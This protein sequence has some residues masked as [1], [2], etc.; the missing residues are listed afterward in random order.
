MMKTDFSAL[1]RWYY[2]QGFNIIPVHFK[3]KKPL[4]SWKEWQEKNI[5]KEIY[6]VFKKKEFVGNNCALITGKIY[7][8]PNI[9]K[10]L[11][12]IDIDNKL[13]IDIFLSYFGEK[14][15]EG[16][17]QKTIVVQ[18]EDSKEE[19]AHIYFISEK[20]ITKRGRISG[21]NKDDKMIPLIEVKS[22][23]STYVVCPPSIYKTGYQYQIIG[24]NQIQVLNEENCKMLEDVLDRIYQK[25]S[26][27]YNPSTSSFSFLT[28]ELKNMAKTLNIDSVKDKIP[29]GARNNTL[30]AVGD[31]LL[32]NHYNS[33]D[34]ELLKDFF[35]KINEKLCEK[36][37]ERKELE[38]IW[39]QAV[40]YIK[41]SFDEKPFTKNY[42]TRQINNSQTKEDSNKK[43]YTVFKFTSN[44]HIYEAVI[45][46]GK[47]FFITFDNGY[48]KIVEEIDD[49]TRAIKP[50]PLEEYASEPY[51]FENKEE[52]VKLVKMIKVKGVSIDSLFF[53][54]NEFV[55]KFIVHH[56]H[57]LD[58]ISVLILFSYFQ[59]RFP[60]VPYTMFVSDNSSGKSSIGNVF[61]TLGYRTINMTDPTTANVFRIFGTVE[62]GQ[63]TLVL[64][65]AEKIDQ[66]KDMMSILKTG[67]EN[68]KKV[69]RINPFTNKPDHY[70]TFGLKMMLAERS[71]NPSNSRGILDRTFVI[72]N[73]KGRPQLNIKEVKNPLKNSNNEK[74][75]KDLLFIKKTLLIFRL[76]HLHKIQDIET[77]LEDRDKEL[78]K[79]ILQLF[80]GS[81][82]QK[83]IEQAL[84]I[85]L[86]DKNNR[87]ANSLER[88]IL[89]VVVGLLYEYPNGNIPF[90]EIW[91]RIIIKTD[92]Q[93]D[94]YKE[95]KLETEMYGSVY[96]MTISRLLRDKFGAKDPVNRNSN[97]RLLS[98]NAQEIRNH[99]DNYTKYKS[100]TKINCR[101]LDISD[102]NDSND[103]NLEDLFE[104]MFSAGETDPQCDNLHDIHSDNNTKELVS[105]C[106]NE[107]IE[108]NKEI[109][110]CYYNCDVQF[111]TKDAY[112]KHS[113]ITHPHRTA[114]P[115]KIEIEKYGLK[116]QGKSW[117]TLT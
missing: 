15:L 82:P 8:G 2:N 81:K 30:L 114:F 74:I 91:A 106:N 20:P 32:S 51:V 29:D 40:S 87:K 99:L 37:L 17:S 19:K 13:G 35:F 34:I 36:P 55:S 5:S 56:P 113:A 11:I 49:E 68:G 1:D 65:E 14:S 48:L 111:E 79:P 69:Q 27:N 57:I 45:I 16:L 53:V 103:S 52:I 26:I 101:P 24:T 44:T 77:G 93:V 12:C 54:V 89:E 18:H 109:F 60:T 47:P 92:G 85:L 64:D 80:Y 28:D 33:K 71:P 3:N 72:S 96:K 117:E 107:L 86:D 115:S 41:K 50:P 10:F 94:Q 75:R 110:R 23:S 62:A 108:N 42:K 31:S 43:E 21:H 105:E 25:Y 58:Y 61:E 39:N 6:E 78:S 73:H 95:Y 67:Y 97:A 9:G 22:D 102:S 90:S 100:P 4:N 104:R 38:S 98:F 7:R 66:D 83:R 112:L 76:L 70:H 63:C 88:D 84:E 46:S 59:D 116:P